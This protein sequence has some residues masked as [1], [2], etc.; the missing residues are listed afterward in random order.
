[1]NIIRSSDVVTSLAG[2]DNGRLYMVLS[3]EGPYAFLSDG[4][5]RKTLN[6]KRKKLKHIAFE[7]RMKSTL[8][9]I[10]GGGGIISDSEIRRE[11]AIYRSKAQNDRGG[12][13]DWQRTM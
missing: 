9:D 1:M 5:V 13:I 6:P 4:K 12:D 3:V 10:L 11:L 2:H 8:A 7:S